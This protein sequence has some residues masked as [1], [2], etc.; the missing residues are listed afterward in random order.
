MHYFLS[1]VLPSLEILKGFMKYYFSIFLAHVVR[2]IYEI[3]ENARISR[4]CFIYLI[5]QKKT[6]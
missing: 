5:W 1:L 4:L 2:V 3:N 6:V